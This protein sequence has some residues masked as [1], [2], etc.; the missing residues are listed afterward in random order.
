MSGDASLFVL[1]DGTGGVARDRTIGQVV[2]ESI[3]DG[4]SSL[5]GDDGSESVSVAINRALA[6]ANRRVTTELRQAPQNGL[7]ST[8]VIGL[9]I[10]SRLF[11]KSVGDTRAYLVRD[12]R[13]ERLTIDQTVSQLLIGSGTLAPIRLSKSYRNTLLSFI[14][15]HDFR[16]ND[17]LRTVDLRVGD[18]V[19]FCTDG[20]SGA[21]DDLALAQI[22]AQSESPVAA[23]GALCDE[24]LENQ[25]ADDITSAVLFVNRD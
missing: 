3:V 10:G 15:Q 12:R 1:A 18:R 6:D 13:P 17:E 4:L 14:G 23:V 11:V 7:G 9:R 19:L 20:L 8:V 22:I 16:P 25:S 2:V 21:V 24:A 5:N